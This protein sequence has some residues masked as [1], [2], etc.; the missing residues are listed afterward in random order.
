VVSNLKK[1]CKEEEINIHTII[2][3]LTLIFIKS[4]TIGSDFNFY[5]WIKYGKLYTSY[6]TNKQTFSTFL[7]NN[8]QE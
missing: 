2:I 5:N 4:I 7:N 1:K 6:Y 8:E 3:I